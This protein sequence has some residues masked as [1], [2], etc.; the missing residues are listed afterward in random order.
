MEKISLKQREDGATLGAIKNGAKFIFGA[1][2]FK[3]QKDC[4]DDMVFCTLGE[5]EAS[6]YITK[7][8][9]VVPITPAVH[10]V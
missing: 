8:A 10:A 3:K 5:T 1:V 7:Y 4:E 6:V 9:W 2:E